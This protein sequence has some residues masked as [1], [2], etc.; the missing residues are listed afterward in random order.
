MR[1]V[2]AISGASGAILALK[3]VSK[4]LILNNSINLYVIISDGA[5]KV[6]KLENGI[7]IDLILNTKNSCDYSNNTYLQNLINNKSKLHIFDNNSLEAPISSGS[8][9]IDGMIILPCSM[10]TLA[11]I[12]SGISD[13]LITRSF[14]VNLKEKRKIIIAPR[15]MPLNPII[16]NNMQIL[17]NAGVSIAPPMFGYY[18]NI[19]TL[20]DMEDFIFGKY[21]DSLGINNNLYKRWGV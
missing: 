7:D 6:L 20:E 1:L 3:F 21:L 14:L 18:A 11:K 13:S 16:I 8:F 17:S 5:K 9:L 4:I 12:A 19:K 10:N 2:V 15:E